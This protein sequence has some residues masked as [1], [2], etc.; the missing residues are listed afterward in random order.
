M[1]FGGVALVVGVG[2]AVAEVREGIKPDKA[3]SGSA[4]TKR[5][6]TTTAT[7]IG[8]PTSQ[9]SPSPVEQLK[10]QQNFT[11]SY[12]ENTG[13]LELDE[14]RAYNGDEEEPAQYVDLAF[15]PTRVQARGVAQL[16][17][18]EVGGREACER[19]IEGEA[20]AEIAMGQVQDDKGF[21][22]RSGEE[23]VAYVKL[24]NVVKD[25]SDYTVKVRV[26]AYK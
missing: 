19:A 21:C 20:P 13:Y 17:L 5:P 23:L 7:P 3:A 1:T 18:S 11:L 8:T 22:A 26:T 24:L 15:D 9:R 12:I 10:Y 2:L 14:P 4:G 6:G 25:K 16:A